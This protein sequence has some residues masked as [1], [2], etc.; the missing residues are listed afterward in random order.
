[1]SAPVGSLPSMSIVLSVGAHA[2]VHHAFRW[3]LGDVP[4]WIGSLATVGALV[5]AVYA[6]VVARRLYDIESNRERT[7]E[8]DR[9]IAAED[10][11]AAAEDRKRAEEDR[12]ARIDD[13]R[14]VQANKV[15]A[16]Y[17]AQPDESV[18]FELDSIPPLIERMQFGAIVQNASGLPIYDL[19]VSFRFPPA[20]GIDYSVMAIERSLS[21]P[22]RVVP[23]GK[24]FI[25]L[26]PSVLRQTDEAGY[27]NFVV[28]IEFRDAAG[29]RWSRDVTGKLMNLPA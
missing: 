8:E 28:A 16:W 19:R 12:L 24:A 6:G 20:S 29:A 7:A 22:I 27:F 15:A 14:R 18:V 5:A 21:E 23:P 11:R 26:N 13:Q 1:M 10:R 17:D 9:R 3:D 25:R 4:T 2:T